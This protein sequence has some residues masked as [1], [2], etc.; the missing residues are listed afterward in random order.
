MDK[1]N[2][3]IVVAYLK[4]FVASVCFQYLPEGLAW[5]KKQPLTCRK[6]AASETKK[7]PDS[8]KFRLDFR[9]CGKAENSTAWMRKAKLSVFAK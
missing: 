7:M 5:C 6:A 2:G 3:N 4:P 1:P 9:R 8:T